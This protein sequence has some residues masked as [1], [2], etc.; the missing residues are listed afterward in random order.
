[1]KLAK[2]FSKRLLATEDATQWLQLYEQKPAFE[3]TG[4]WHPTH[5]ELDIAV[6][7]ARVGYFY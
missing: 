3:K 1:M 2:E 6:G 7:W 5:L 4:L